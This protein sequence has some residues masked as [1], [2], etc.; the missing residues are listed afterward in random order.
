[1]EE[2]SLL[3]TALSGARRH[4]QQPAATQRRNCVKDDDPFHD[5]DCYGHDDDDPQHDQTQN[6]ALLVDLFLLSSCGV[7]DITPADHWLQLAE[8]A[9]A[10]NE[11][12][13]SSNT[14]TSNEKNDEYPWIPVEMDPCLVYTSPL[15]T[16][17]TTII[18][19]R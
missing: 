10:L 8:T 1:M 4:Q 3:Q 16:T 15:Q 9:V 12:I 17:T 6:A 14:T 2:G 19:D 13:M 5:D 7:N 11:S 18:I